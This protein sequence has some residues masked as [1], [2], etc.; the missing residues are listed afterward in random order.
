MDAEAVA[1]RREL[2]L[3]RAA[4]DSVVIHSIRVGEML[5][6][7]KQQLPHGTWYRW[8]DSNWPLTRRRAQQFMEFARKAKDLSHLETMSAA[9]RLLHPP[10]P[11]RRTLPPVLSKPLKPIPHRR[12]QLS[13]PDS[14]QPPPGYVPPA[15]SK[16]HKVR[17]LEAGQWEEFCD[18]LGAPS[19]GRDERWLEPAALAWALEILRSASAPHDG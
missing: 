4:A 9:Q 1:I 5:V 14:G 18:R 13:L 19:A 12:G 8:L 6:D 2:A 10:R 16:T 17:I 3:A 15:P 7:V 11:P